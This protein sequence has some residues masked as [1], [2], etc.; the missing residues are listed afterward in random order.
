MK[1][2]PLARLMIL[3][4]RIYQRTFASFLGGRCR[5]EPTCSVYGLEAIERHGAIRGGWLTVKRISRCHPW[6]GCGHDPVP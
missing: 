6:G 2:T 3:F 1:P 4:I 5:F